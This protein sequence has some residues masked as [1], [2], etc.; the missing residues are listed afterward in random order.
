VRH[1]LRR[2]RAA[3]RFLKWRGEAGVEKFCT[4]A[5]LRWRAR[6]CQR[7]HFQPASIPRRS[8]LMYSA[9][10]QSR[11]T[12]RPLSPQQRCESRHSGTAALGQEADKSINGVQR[13]SDA[14]GSPDLKLSERPAVRR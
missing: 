1:R 13:Q 10:R 9:I 3:A 8:A 11:L 6:R 12:Q 2:L 14:A 7:A 4:A 5:C